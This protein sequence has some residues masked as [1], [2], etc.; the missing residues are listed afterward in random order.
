MMGDD[1][2]SFDNMEQQVS[3]KDMN[4]IQKLHSVIYHLDSFLWGKLLWHSKLLQLTD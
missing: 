3:A 1:L 4:A 2:A